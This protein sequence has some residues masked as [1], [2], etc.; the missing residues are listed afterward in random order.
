MS[1]YL[2]LRLFIRRLFCCWIYTLH[3]IIIIDLVLIISILI[4]IGVAY[5]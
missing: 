3:A 4:A 2:L 1:A 5:K